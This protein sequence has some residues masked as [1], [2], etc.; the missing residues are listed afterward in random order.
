MCRT[1]MQQAPFNII[2]AN[3]TCGIL[4]AADATRAVQ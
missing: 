1:F 3:N 2:T 4:T